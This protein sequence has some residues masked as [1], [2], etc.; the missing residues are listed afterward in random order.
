ME[1]LCG[2][3]PSVR[4]CVYVCVRA[5]QGGL[6]SSLPDSDVSA[7]SVQCLFT[8]SMLVM[9]TRQEDRSANLC[10]LLLLLLLEEIRVRRANGCIQFNIC[11]L[12]LVY[13][14]N[15]LSTIA[16]TTKMNLLYTGTSIE[17]EYMLSIHSAEWSLSKLITELLFLFLEKEK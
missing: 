16:D 6:V 8:A 11:L 14:L 10:T 15:L 2:H 12:F 17:V 1:G 5:K 13:F 4:P 3:R 7:R 9:G